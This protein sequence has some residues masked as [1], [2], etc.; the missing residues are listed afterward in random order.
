MLEQDVPEVKVGSKQVGSAITPYYGNSATELE[1]PDKFHWQKYEQA[2][3][4][5]YIISRA[6]NFQIRT[7]LASIGDY[8]HPNP[9][10]RDFVKKNLDQAEGNLQKWIFELMWSGLVYGRGVSEINWVVRD[11]QVFINNLVSYHPRSISLVVSLDGVLTDGKKNPYS[12]LF[13]KT[14]VWQ[15]LPSK[16][17]MARDNRL[18]K[19]A[20]LSYVRIPLNKV[21]LVTHAGKF[22]NYDGESALAPIWDSYQRKVKTRD[23]LMITAERYGAPLVAITAPFAYTANTVIDEQTNQPRKE[24]L[25]E[26]I[27]RN[28][29]HLSTSTGLV[30]EEPAL[31]AAQE[32][33]RIQTVTTGNNFGD[34]FLNVLH[35]LDAEILL[36]LGVPPLLFLEQR[37]GLGSGSL[38][39]T[40]ADYY[41]ET[42]VTLFKEFVEPFTEQVI[43]RLVYYNFGD[44]NPGKFSF[45][46]FD[47]SAT[48]KLMLVIETGAALGLFDS[49]DPQDLQELRTRTG[50]SALDE[51]RLNAR[52]KSNK[53]A[54]VNTKDPDKGKIEIAKLRLAGQKYVADKHAKI[55]LEAAKISAKS[56]PNSTKPTK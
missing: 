55:Q 30:I 19:D 44:T 31:G 37:V 2:V 3:R 33:V 1:G 51:Q 42:L 49:S 17:L 9:K 23:D 56:R 11:N 43:G 22:G 29:E 15:E 21:C 13:P 12:S 39:A 35:Q 14:G 38:A 50:F 10:I 48:E 40:Q 8:T 25:A 34:S 27:S 16:I 5:D 28:M 6:I 18:K 20:F 52:A 32:K 46:P 54:M 47:I 7:M 41:K 36:G 26:S 4:R 24:T 45:T 53:E